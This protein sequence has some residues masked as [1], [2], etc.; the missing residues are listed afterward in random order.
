MLFSDIS[1]S[2]RSMT[3]GSTQPLVKM[4]FRNIPGG[5]G[6]RCVRLTTSPPSR[7]ECHE[8]REPKPP[9]TVWATPGL[10][11]GLLSFYFHLN[12]LKFYKEKCICVRTV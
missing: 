9:V 12:V 11:R 2:D 4:S 1:P 3:L 8:I 6:G 5:K 7:A 10:L